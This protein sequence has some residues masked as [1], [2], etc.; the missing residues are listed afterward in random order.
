MVTDPPY[1]L[2]APLNS[3]GKKGHITPVEKRAIP[4]WDR[5]LAV[6]DEILALWSP[7]PAV[8]FGSVTKPAPP[9]C[10]QRPLVWDK[11]EAVGMGDTSFPWRPNYEL[12]WVLGAGF[13]GPRTSSILRYPIVPGG[14]DHPTQKP[15]SLMVDLL[16]KCPPGVVLDPF[17]GSGTTLRAAKDIGRR[18]I[19]IELDEGYC[20]TA[21]RRFAQECLDLEAA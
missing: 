12:V 4:D 13:A 7:R 9:G 16:Q 2:D 6:R 19:G 1:G 11:G 15:V 18:A 10:T 14:R 17:A 3:G 21:A 5:D 20:D 8:V